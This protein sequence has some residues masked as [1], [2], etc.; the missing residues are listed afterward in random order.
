[1][2][3][4]RFSLS[5]WW[6][7]AALRWSVAPVFAA[8][9]V[10]AL[11]YFLPAAGPAVYLEWRQGVDAQ[12][13]A[14]LER[15]H[16]LLAPTHIAGTTWGYTLADASNDNVSR[17]LAL[18]E[19]VARVGIDP[20]P[21]RVSGREIIRLAGP[22]GV[23]SLIG[24]LVGGLLIA[25]AGAPTARIRQVYFLVAALL[26]AVSGWTARLP[27]LASHEVSHWMGDYD[28]YTN[29]RDRFHAYF[30]DS[31]V[32]FH[33][34]LGGFIVSLIDRALGSTDTSP[35]AAFR[36]LSG[37][38]GVVALLQAATVAM[39][40]RWSA[41]SMRYAGLCVAAPFALMFFGYR[42]LAYLSLSVAA[43]PLLLMTFDRPEDSRNRV[44]TRA[45]ASLQGL[46]A[47]MHGLGLSA[48]ASLMAI[49]VASAT[50]L[51]QGIFRTQ[52]IFGWAFIAYAIWL[53]MYIML[54]GRPIVPGHASGI[55]V[56][57]LF[58][59]YVAENRTV[60]ALVSL[61]ALRDIGME[62]LVVGVPVVLIALAVSG[63]GSRRVVIA[64]TAVSA[65]VLLLIWPAQGI[66]QDIDT[67]LATFP[68]F[69]VGAWVCAARPWSGV[70]AFWTLV[71]GHVTF[72]FV[73]RSAAFTNPGL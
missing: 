26:L 40:S 67:V 44:L 42:E 18:P 7:T 30:G 24:L 22:L 35:H 2:S 57:A 48:V 54:L 52:V 28:T 64:G 36:V 4:A 19:V 56:R 39:L 32:R 8:A 58:Q 53:P 50:S 34:H 69:F 3:R 41:Q 65:A 38:M 61:E 47:A 16:R 25:G 17:L 12:T 43:F 63:R 1:M 9:L 62:A 23:Q 71:I 66:G 21:P 49:A 27:V 45:A 14:A 10:W 72:W 46:H 68:A 31:S 70:A 15:Q 6:A 51:R 33:F 11:L 20:D 37:L 60:E 29:N 73:I 13:R 55:P 5:A 59:S